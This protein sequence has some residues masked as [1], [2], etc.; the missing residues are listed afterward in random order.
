MLYSNKFLFESKYLHTIFS[1]NKIYNYSLLSGI[2]SIIVVLTLIILKITLSYSLMVIIMSIYIFIVVILNSDK[3]NKYLLDYIYRIDITNINHM[4]TKSF[5]KYYVT[6][7][8]LIKK[9]KCLY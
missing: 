8:H 9:K 4:G 3:I 2:S 5:K 1:Q 7:T 6:F